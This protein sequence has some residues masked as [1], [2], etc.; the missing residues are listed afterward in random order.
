[1]R[2]WNIL[3]ES[4]HG[5]NKEKRRSSVREIDVRKRGERKEEEVYNINPSSSS[6]AKAQADAATSSPSS[7]THPSQSRR[8]RRSASS[9]IDERQR[10]NSITGFEPIG[11]V[12]GFDGFWSRLSTEPGRS[13][14]DYRRIFTCRRALVYRRRRSVSPL[15]GM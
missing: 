7:H 3:N 6:Q 2:L 9:A 13:V 10:L 14:R 12:D 11:N 1:M 15:C 8:R 5:M 4:I